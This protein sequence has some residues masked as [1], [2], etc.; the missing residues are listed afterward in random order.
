MFPEQP[1]I[2]DKVWGRE[3]WYANNQD[4][5]YCGK[6]LE[7]NSG[8]KLSMHFHLLKDEMFY[9]LE[10]DCDVVI[11]DTAK[12]KEIS[13]HLSPG[14]CYHIKQGLPHRLIAITDC[15][16][17]EASTFHRDSDSYRVYR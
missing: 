5:D 16:I 1:K 11:I 9:V 10:G 14:D 7:I 2:V 6:V 13:C 15:K 12:A 4:K 3:I 17:L 8:E